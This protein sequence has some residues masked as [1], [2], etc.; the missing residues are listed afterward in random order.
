[1]G[2]NDRTET[3]I[4]QCGGQLPDDRQITQVAAHNDC[5]VVYVSSEGCSQTVEF[6]TVHHQRLLGQ[7]GD[8]ELQARQQFSTVPA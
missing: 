3:G 4:A 8:A 7:T 5:G 1:M 2:S 6:D